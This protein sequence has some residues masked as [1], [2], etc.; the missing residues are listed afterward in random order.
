MTCTP[1]KGNSSSSSDDTEEEINFKP[2]ELVDLGVYSP[3]GK[4]DN[5]GLPVFIIKN[6]INSFKCGRWAFLS[7]EDNMVYDLTTDKSAELHEYAARGVQSYV[8]KCSQD[9]FPM[10]NARRDP[11]GRIHYLFGIPYRG[12]W[13][14]YESGMN[15]FIPLFSGDEMEVTISNGY[16]LPN[17]RHT[18]KKTLR[19]IKHFQPEDILACTHHLESMFPDCNAV[20]KW[21]AD[22]VFRS[23]HAVSCLEERTSAI[24]ESYHKLRHR[25]SEGSEDD[26]G[27][28]YLGSA[29]ESLQCIAK[30]L[31]SEMKN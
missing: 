24:I 23:S 3:L 22:I 11:S 2:G 1:I 26:S 21:P 12:C 6:Y 14:D 29:L 5:V 28:S 8:R 17:R 30:L 13:K 16:G 10:L 31:E 25:V 19:V 27:I 7:D 18:E 15:A 4:E 20:K 9:E